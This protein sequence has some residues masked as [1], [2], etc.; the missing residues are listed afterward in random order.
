MPPRGTV[1]A[2]AESGCLGTAHGRDSMLVAYSFLD[3]MLSI[4][5]FFAWVI[6]F[7]LLITVLADLYSR[8]DIS[9]WGKAAWTIFC[10]FLPLIGVLTYLIIESDGMAERSARDKR[11]YQAE[12]DDYIK[13]V[14]G[15]ADP[16]QTIAKGKELLDQGAISS[17]EYDALKRRVLAPS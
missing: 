10:I 9:G 6:W 17:A 7:W 16:A 14:A 11:A 2:N 5:V 15:T 1:P 8:H 4:L 13:S 12:T 3:V